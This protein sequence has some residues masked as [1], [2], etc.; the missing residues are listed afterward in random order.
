MTARVEDT[1]DGYK[2]T[3]ACELVAEG[4]GCD[5]AISVYA[6]WQPGGYREAPGCWEVDAPN[7]CPT[8]GAELDGDAIIDE[9]SEAVHEHKEGLRDAYYE[10]KMDA[11]RAGDFD[12]ERRC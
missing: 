5:T 6:N 8:C 3:L 2:V 4:E 12:D 10:D 11:E 9:A 1:R 7:T